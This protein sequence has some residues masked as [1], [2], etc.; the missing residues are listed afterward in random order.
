MNGDASRRPSHNRATF[1]D[2]ELR[3]PPLPQTMTEA[4]N[5]TQHPERL[6]VAAVMDIVRRD[7]VVV[8]RLLTIVNSAYYGLRHQVT[9]VDR[10]V[11]ML[12][13]VAVIGIV[14]GMQ[15]MKLRELM[16]GPAAGCFNRLIRHSVATAFIA[17]HL[18]EGPPRSGRRR[19]CELG[20]AFTAGLLHDFGKIILVYNFPEKAVSLYD[21]GRLAPQVDAEDESELEQL[22]FGYDHQEA[23]EYTAR[24][25][26]FPDFLIE[27]I[28]HHHRPPLS[29]G[30]AETD[31]V[32]R[33]VAAGN[34]ASRALGHAFTR[35]LHPE[36]CVSAPIW[37]SIV[38]L[39][40]GRYD[41]GEALAR[42]ILALRVSLD[43]YVGSM[44]PTNVTLMSNR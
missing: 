5:L 29:A 34:L 38:S 20:P 22:V 35:P 12:G 16:D 28:R 6:E 14:M 39:D 18:V 17:R 40:P 19:K 4:L 23:G 21:E 24:K 25:L 3:C 37:Q 26:H 33:A 27:V 32:V 31:R 30:N 42:E 36:E 44:T 1:A 13:P 41:S 43:Q 10:A 7:P 11:I 2:L 8:A 15:M 9:S